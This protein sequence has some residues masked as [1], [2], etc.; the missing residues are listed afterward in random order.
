M[1]FF[2]NQAMGMGNSGIEHAEFYRA[3]SFARAQIPY[4]FVF[5]GMVPE[6]HEAMTKWRLKSQ[7]VINMWEYF[8]WG[9]DYL[10]KGLTKTFPAKKVRS[11]VDST[12]TVRMN[13]Q[14]ASSG[15]RIVNHFVKGKNKQKPESK[16]LM[17]RAYRTQI[18]NSQTGELKVAFETLDNAHE[19]ARM[20]NIHLYSEHGEHLYFANIVRLYHYFF[21]QLDR[22]FGSNSNFYIDRGDWAD[23]ALMYDEIPNAK[24]IYLIH[25]DHL[26]DRVD[27]KK[28]FWNNY[29]EYL[30]D[31][32]N[33]V[34]RVVV[35][36]EQ[37]RQDLLI[38]FPKEGD[39]IWAIPVGG[40]SD[41]SKV[42]KDRQPDGLRFITASRLAK[43]K[44]IDVAVRAVAQLHDAGYKISFDIYGQGEEKKHLEQM[45]KDYHAEDY[46][47]LRG[48]S[49]HL[50]KVYPKYDAFISTSFSEGFGLT[51]IEALNA[52][53]PVV[54]FNARFGATQLIRDGENGF[55]QE[56]K[57][58]DDDFN[59]AQIKEGIVRLFNADYVQM[60]RNTQ[61]GI[62]EYRDSAIAKKWRKLVDGLRTS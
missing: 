53:L 11:L 31:H 44:H 5:L 27:P 22:F 29:Y 8:V 47:R 25:A 59:V 21:C 2:V 3:K 57:R 17:V 49:Q 13:E 46:I 43:E 55:V 12:N 33:K 10:K 45:I 41:R 40:I 39:K 16:L 15:L 60:R 50:E 23:E 4:R 37:Q 56:L 7:N 28:P 54:T 26:A 42:I 62:D 24:I 58:E 19:Q 6:L 30:L 52:A 51:Y 36:T 14:Y 38:D 18:F 20:Q 34:D 32:L 9:D 35:S 1:D 61:V 48:L